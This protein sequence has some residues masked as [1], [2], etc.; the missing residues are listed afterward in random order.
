MPWRVWF[1]SKRPL[2]AGVHSN[3]EMLDNE[4]DIKAEPIPVLRDG[5]LAEVSRDIARGAKFGKPGVRK[6]GG[7]LQRPMQG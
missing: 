6:D 3:Q 4:N 7:F 1:L 5:D 2:N